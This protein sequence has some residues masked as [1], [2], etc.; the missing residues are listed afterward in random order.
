MIDDPWSSFSSEAD[1]NLASCFVRSKVSTSQI[2][3]DF[4]EGLGGLDG[5]SF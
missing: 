1:F 5:R 2:D 3:R 4:A